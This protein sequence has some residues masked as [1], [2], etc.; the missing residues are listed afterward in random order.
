MKE[1]LKIKVCE[2][3][4]QCMGLTDVHYTLRKSQ[5]LQLK[6]KRRENAQTENSNVNKLNPNRAIIVTNKY[7]SSFSS[8]NVNVKFFS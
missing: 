6:K 1:L 3:C 5:Q 2:S 7:F 4:E 8:S